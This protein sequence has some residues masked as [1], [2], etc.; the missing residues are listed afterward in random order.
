M[1]FLLPV[2]YFET[3]QFVYFLQ[4]KKRRYFNVKITILRPPDYDPILINNIDKIERAIY[5]I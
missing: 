5:I 3:E 1:K 2:K 4:K